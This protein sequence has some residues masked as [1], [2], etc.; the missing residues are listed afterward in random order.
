IDYL[1]KPVDADKLVKAVGKVHAR[2]PQDR[3]EHHHQLTRAVSGQ[4]RPI[5]RIGLPTSKGR[6][7]IAVADIVYCQ[8]DGGY[9]KFFGKKEKG[10]IT[11]L[12]M[13]SDSLNEFEKSLN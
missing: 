2:S 8:S 1:L 7:F 11:L 5:Q 3:A 12:G 9:T 6:L 10:Q 4:E 13:A